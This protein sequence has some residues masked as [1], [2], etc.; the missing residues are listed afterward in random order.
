GYNHH[1]L[2]RCPNDGPI[3]A[4]P[5][6]IAGEIGRRGKDVPAGQWANDGGAL[7][8]AWRKRDHCQRAGIRDTVAVPRNFNG[9]SARV[10]QDET[11]DVIKAIRLTGN[12]NS[13]LQPS[14]PERSHATGNS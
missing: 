10:G 1:L 11:S 12:F 6:A 4:Q 8:T 5:P 2:V 13:V 9:I 7:D 3:T 14:I